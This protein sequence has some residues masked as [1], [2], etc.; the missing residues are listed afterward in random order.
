MKKLTVIKK[1]LQRINF[2]RKYLDYCTFNHVMISQERMIYSFAFYMK[3]K[4][5]QEK[6]VEEIR[7]ELL[8]YIDEIF[9]KNQDDENEPA[10][11]WAKCKEAQKPGTDLIW[12]LNPG[13]DVIAMADKVI[14]PSASS[15]TITAGGIYTV[16]GRVYPG[17]NS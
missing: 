16:K 4:E 10:D 11:L 14:F 8:E 12:P 6:I 15:Y 17:T 7:K 3:S 1:I 2:M 5:E 13:L 9:S